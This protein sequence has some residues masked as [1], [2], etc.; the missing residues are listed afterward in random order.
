[1]RNKKVKPVAIDLCCGAGGLTLGLKRAGFNV[2]AGVE[3]KSEIAHTYSTNH[4]EVEL[5]IDDIRNLSGKDFLK[6]VPTSTIDLVA[7]CPPCQGFSK[8]TDKYHRNDPRNDLVLEMARLIEEIQPKMVMFENVSG[9]VTRGK[10]ILD[11]FILRLEELD[12]VIN[13]D[14]LQLA[15]YGVPQSRRRFVLLAGKGFSVPLPPKTHSNKMNSQLKPWPTLSDIIGKMGQAVTISEANAKG[16]P[17]KF[18]WHV[19]RDITELSRKR[20]RSLKPG[21]NRFDLPDTLRP[22]CHKG[23]NSG[24]RNVYGRISWDQ[25]PPTMTT[26]FA[27][28][29]KG[30]FGHPDEIRTLSVL[31][32]AKIQTFPSS[33][34]FETNSLDVATDLVGNGLPPQFAFTLAKRCFKS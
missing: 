15:D 2:I 6:L 8:L 10:E 29:C 5:F 30:R 22:N 25:T 26:G 11:E 13:M 1:M 18:N 16:G 27:T 19:V 14:V 17:Q 20:Y 3:F 21:C 32:A 12:Y 31:E 7:G 28:P 4:P 9:I 24:F 34:R 33:Y 23:N